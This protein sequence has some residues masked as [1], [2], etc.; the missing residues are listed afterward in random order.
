V[1]SGAG[2]AYFEI[3]RA[4][5]GKYTLRIDDVVLEDHAFDRENSVLSASIVVR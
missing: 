1:T 4:R 5:R 3:D 2:V